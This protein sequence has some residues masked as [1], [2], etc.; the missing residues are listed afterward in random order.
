MDG[1]GGWTE[2]GPLNTMT[3]AHGVSRQGAGH[4][5]LALLLS[6]SPGER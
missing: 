3:L 2:A 1:V 5:I 6:P 4:A